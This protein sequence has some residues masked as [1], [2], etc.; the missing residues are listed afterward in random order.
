MK[1]ISLILVAISLFVFS[2][3]NAQ[4]KVEVHNQ[5]EHVEEQIQAAMDAAAIRQAMRDIE[6]GSETEKQLAIQM[7]REQKK[8]RKQKK[9]A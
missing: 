9:Q 2:N 3:A 7:L 5:D 8:R 6:F 1:K 4:K